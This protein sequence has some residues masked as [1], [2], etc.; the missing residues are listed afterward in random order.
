MN[1]LTSYRVTNLVSGAWFEFDDI[2]TGAKAVKA[3]N[4]VFIKWSLSPMMQI[5]FYSMENS[6]E[7]HKII[8][9]LE[10]SIVQHEKN[11]Q[12]PREHILQ[13]CKVLWFLSN[14]R[15][16]IVSVEFIK[17]DRTLRK[18]TGIPILE[19]LRLDLPYVLFHEIT[20]ENVG[21]NYRHVNLDTLLLL[22]VDN[23]IYY[24]KD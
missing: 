20:T 18:L 2:S 5:T 23:R 19:N 9:D 3:S 6:S 8:G 21:D 11:P 14:Y 7:C 13:R 12:G 22:I 17:K 4:P 1:F 24:I 10:F 15:N 16:S